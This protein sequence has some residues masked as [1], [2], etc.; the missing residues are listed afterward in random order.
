MTTHCCPPVTG[1]LGLYR[2]LQTPGCRLTYRLRLI[3]CLTDVPDEFAALFAAS[4]ARSERHRPQRAGFHADGATPAYVLPA[5]VRL[6]WLERPRQ[7]TF[8]FASKCAEGVGTP[9]NYVDRE[10]ECLRTP[11]DDEPEGTG[12]ARAPFKLDQLLATPDERRPVL[13]EVKINDDEDAVYALVQVL[14][15]A[16]YLSS[17]AQRHCIRLHYGS[18]L[19]LPGAGPYFDL[20][21]VLFRDRG[22]PL[23]GARIDCLQRATSL[24]ATLV[25]RPEVAA[26][27][28][29]IVFVESWLEDGRLRFAPAGTTPTL[30]DP[31]QR[32]RP[33]ELTA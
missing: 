8:L 15:A 24:A 29:E 13:A 14:A 19:D 25:H 21:V 10:L 3:Q 2:H 18:W 12:D 4:V 28:R 31:L 20:R 5:P 26:V 1:M 32:R 7:A 30:G 33:R 11:A 17:P 9:V 27:V 23:K 22:H 16:A 6:P